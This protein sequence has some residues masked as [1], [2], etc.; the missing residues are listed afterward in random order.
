[1]ESVWKDKKMEKGVASKQIGF[2]DT[3][4]Q[5]NDTVYLTWVASE[6]IFIYTQRCL[7]LT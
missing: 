6:N 3:W 2:L 4:M 7:L 5:V 1:M